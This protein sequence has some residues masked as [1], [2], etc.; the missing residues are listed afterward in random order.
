MQYYIAVKSVNG[1]MITL[2]HNNFLGTDEA[3]KGWK[4]TYEKFVST[5]VD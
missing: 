2:W 3:F 1:T 5:I 4:E